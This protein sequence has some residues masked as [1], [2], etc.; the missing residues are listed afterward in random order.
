MATLGALLRLFDEERGVLVVDLV[1]GGEELQRRARRD[2]GVAPLVAR[3]RSGWSACCTATSPRSPRA[4]GGARAVD[5]LPGGFSD[6]NLAA[7]PRAALDLR[8]IARD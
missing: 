7:E 4:A 6:E 1:E 2:G 5:P 3:A 8:D